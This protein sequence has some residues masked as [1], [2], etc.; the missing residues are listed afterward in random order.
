LGG[1]VE[2]YLLSGTL[3]FTIDKGLDISGGKYQQIIFLTTCYKYM[4]T[5]L[6]GEKPALFV[7]PLILSLC[8]SEKPAENSLIELQLYP[9]NF[10][11]IHIP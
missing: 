9:I 6:M 11:S 1:F 5:A 3:P 4:R 10:I 2:I 8:I 7:I